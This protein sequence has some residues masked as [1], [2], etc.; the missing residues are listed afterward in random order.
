MNASRRMPR[1]ATAAGLLAS[2]LAATS[3]SGCL[4]VNAGSSDPTTGAVGTSTTSSAPTASVI[5]P[6]TAPTQKPLSTGSGL[7]IPLTTDASFSSLPTWGVDTDSAWEIVTFDK[8]GVNQFKH[9]NGCQLTTLQ[10][11][12]ASTAT[13]QAETDAQIA[14]VQQDFKARAPEAQFKVTAELPIYV[15][16]GKS[17][18]MEFG[19]LLVKYTNK[20]TKA[21]WGSLIGVRAMPKVGSLMRVNLSCPANLMSAT[22]P[23]LERLHVL[24]S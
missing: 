4:L 19:A 13:D 15:G 12:L 17:R 24:G 11:R 1:P 6:T 2:T 9:A 14:A 22:I 18:T 16:M 23:T 3:L 20:D 8:D 5:T 7:S 21:E 10:N